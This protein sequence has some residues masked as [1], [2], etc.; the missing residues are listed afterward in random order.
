MTEVKC[1]KNC[2]DGVCLTKENMGV[3][4]GFKFKF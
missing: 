4:S 2:V 1:S 3:L